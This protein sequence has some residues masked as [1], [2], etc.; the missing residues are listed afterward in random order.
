MKVLVTGAN[1]FIGRHVLRCLERHYLEA[2]VLGRVRPSGVALESFI[3]ADLLTC[4]DL[5]ERLGASGATHL[6]HLAWVTEHGAFWESPQNYDWVRASVGLV[7]AFASVGGRHVVAAGSCAEYDWSHGLCRE[8]STPLSPASTYGVAK[9]ATRRLLSALCEGAG[10]SLAW[11]RL[12]LAHGE[13]EDPR[14]LVP[15]LI[16]A[17][18]GAR[19]AFAVNRH[20]W[21][22]FLQAGDVA[23][24]FVALLRYGAR[25]DYNISSGQ[26]LQI[27]DLVREL[28]IQLDADPD[29][30]LGLP[31]VARRGEPGLLLGESR[32][33]QA[34]GWQ[35][36]HSLS[37]ALAETI[38]SRALAGRSMPAA[39]SIPSHAEGT[40]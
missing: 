32:R 17:L 19:P 16:D 6:L 24:G 8:H 12:F 9:D 26:P 14:R 30:V 20:A 33:L 5:D 13:G 10:L 22:D 7:R 2:V 39:R 21:R 37:S 34:L 11:G 18:T 36:R 25:G 31:A 29:A 28:A 23:E 35:P 15:G 1:G 40:S 3:E 27:G 38:A 4:T